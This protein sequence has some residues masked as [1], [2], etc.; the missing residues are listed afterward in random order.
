[1]AGSVPSSSQNGTFAGPQKI[2]LNSARGQSSQA[3]F[4]RDGRIDLAFESG[5]NTL[6][7]WNTT[8]A[9]A[10]ASRSD[11]S[12]REDLRSCAI[13]GKLSPPLCEHDRFDNITGMPCVCHKH[14]QVLFAE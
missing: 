9:A 2:D 11:G 13:D 1:V 7:C 6:S 8:P 10:G 3:N 5:S 4:N 14:F 12:Q